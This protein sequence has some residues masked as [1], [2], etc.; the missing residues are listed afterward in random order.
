MASGGRHGLAQSLFASAF[1]AILVYATALM[2]GKVGTVAG[3]FFGFAF[4]LGGIGAAVRGQL[5]HAT[6]IAFVYKVC[7]FLP[8]IGVLT[9]FLP[10]LESGKRANA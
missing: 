10:D 2:P 9:V 7:S 8:L 5:A 6:S 1:A 4:G 3:L